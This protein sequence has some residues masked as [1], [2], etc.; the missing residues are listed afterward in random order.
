VPS[1]LQNVL[2]IKGIN[3]N[4]LAILKK[5]I[6]LNI[7]FRQFNQFKQKLFESLKVSDESLLP[8]EEFV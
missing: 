3:E 8:I 7:D 4:R 5:L 6:E 2:N 1:Y